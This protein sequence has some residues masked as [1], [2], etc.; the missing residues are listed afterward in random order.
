MIAEDLN[1]DQVVEL[2]KKC[3]DYYKEN[4]KPN[5]RTARFVQRV[6]IEEFKKAVL[7]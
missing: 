6:G 5:E 1:D 7:E 3:L 4:A 2:T